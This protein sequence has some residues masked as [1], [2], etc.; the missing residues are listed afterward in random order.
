MQENEITF[1]PKSYGCHRAPEAP[2]LQG[3]IGSWGWLYF[4]WQLFILSALLAVSKVGNLI[5][6]GAFFTAQGMS[7]SQ[8]ETI[9][10]QSTALAE[11]KLSP[12]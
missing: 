7:Y 9:K 2:C 3:R 1:S 5:K 8:A 11:Q 6:S 10:L 12:D 4:F